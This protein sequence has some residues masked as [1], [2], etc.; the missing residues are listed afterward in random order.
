MVFICWKV[1]YDFP[2]DY[3][4]EISKKAA[5]LLGIN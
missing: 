3:S 2:L 1:V 4:V 5:Q